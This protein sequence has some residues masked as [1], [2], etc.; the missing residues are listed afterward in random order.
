MR[1]TSRSRHLRD[2]SCKCW[3]W[4]ILRF[5]RSSLRMCSTSPSFLMPCVR[6]VQPV[7]QVPGDG[8]PSGL[9]MGEVGC[10]GL[11]RRGLQSGSAPDFVMPQA[12]I[13]FP[14]LRASFGSGA[15]APSRRGSNRG[16]HWM[17]ARWIGTWGFFDWT[18]LELTKISQPS[19]LA[20]KLD[21]FIG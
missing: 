20:R 4:A 6:R 14:P 16:P 19:K 13:P 15:F 12:S 2:R 7:D 10:T 21:V 8:T 11:D 3:I 9:K 5:T 18:L 17:S 1:D